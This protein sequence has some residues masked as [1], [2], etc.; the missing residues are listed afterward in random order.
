MN[1][2]QLRTFIKSLTK[3]KIFGVT[4]TKRDGTL[5]DMT[6]RIGVTK[7]LK[8]GELPYDPV[9]KGLLPV[10]DMNK[11]DPKTNQK[12]CYRMVNLK[13]LKEIRCNGTTYKIQQ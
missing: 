12:G 6:C 13:T 7:H 2:E 3:D 10:F 1:T 11:V 4:F 9:E 5:R 8:G